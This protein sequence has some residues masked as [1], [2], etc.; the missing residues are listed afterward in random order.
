MII[1]YLNCF[2]EKIKLKYNNYKQNFVLI[3]IIIFLNTIECNNLFQCMKNLKSTNR[4]E[5][6][7]V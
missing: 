4:I 2:I 5:R 7:L 1:N 6:L 3:S